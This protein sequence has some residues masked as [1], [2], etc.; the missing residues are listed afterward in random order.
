M[1]KLSKIISMAVMGI[2]LLTS[3]PVTSAYAEGEPVSQPK[4]PEKPKTRHVYK[5]D[6]G[7]TTAW[8]FIGGKWEDTPTGINTPGRVSTMPKFT[9][10]YSDILKPTEKIV[11]AK[12]NYAT[13][14]FP[15][16]Y[17]SSQDGTPQANEIFE[18]SKSSLKY[19]QNWD[20]FRKYYRKR[21]PE[22]TSQ[23]INCT[24][25]SDGKSL[26]RNSFQ[27][28]LPDR[29]KA[30]DFKSALVHAKAGDMFEKNYL[31]DIMGWRN[32]SGQYET[33]PELKKY[34]NRRVYAD[35]LVGV[36]YPIPTVID[37]EIAETAIVPPIDPPDPEPQLDIAIQSA[38]G[39]S[40]IMT[41]ERFA[42]QGTVSA[43][44]VKDEAVDLARKYPVV[45]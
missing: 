35:Y 43:L 30:I 24:I 34:E 21:T 25:T 15:K 32:N 17:F 27:I 42:I 36:I 12:I 33:P 45:I 23:S 6:L 18:Y 2:M 41:G 29:T 38:V 3:V 16:F 19:L 10:N 31:Y 11:S 20:G 44:S 1:K 8:G 7:Y 39:D 26:T 22:P 9:F 28:N 4:A 5:F 40:P 14:P 37:I 13:E